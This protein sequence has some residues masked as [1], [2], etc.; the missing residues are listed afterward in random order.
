MSISCI[1]YPTSLPQADVHINADSVIGT[2]INPAILGYHI[3]T[4][5]HATTK[6][7]DKWYHW[8]FKKKDF[9]RD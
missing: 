2:W 7:K 5:S 4:P 8:S 6:I 1:H 3:Y 9:V